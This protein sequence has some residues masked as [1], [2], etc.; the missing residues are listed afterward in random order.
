MVASFVISSLFFFLVDGVVGSIV[1]FLI[2]NLIDPNQISK[3]F[4][5]GGIVGGPVSS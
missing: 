2:G 3:S 5:A 4:L 1:S